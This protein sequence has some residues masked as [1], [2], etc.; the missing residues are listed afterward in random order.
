MK[1]KTLRFW[2]FKFRLTPTRYVLFALVLGMIGAA[3]V[4]FVFG[5]GAVTNLNDKWPWGLW[6]GFDLLCGIALAGGGFSTALIVHILHK[7]K[8]HSIARGAMLTSLLGYIVALISLLIDIGRWHN[9][10]RP[11]F[12]WGYHSILFEVYWCISMYTLVQILEFADIALE[13]FRFPKLKKILGYAMTPLLILGVVLPTLHQSSLGAL[14]TVMV[15]KLDPL[16]WSMLLP[17]FFV[18]SAFMLGPAMV[19]V[20]GTLWANSYCKQSEVP[21]FR[22][23]TKVTAWMLLF[24]LI[25]KV[26]DLLYRGVFGRL[27][28][29]S[30]TSWMFLAE[31]LIGVII[32]LII[33]A[34]PSLRRNP[35]GILTA[36]ALVVA[37][38]IFNRLN[39][40]F[41]GMV[42]YIGV[43]YIPSVWELLI[44]AGLWSCLILAYCFVIENFNIAPAK[45]L[46]R[47][48]E[49]AG[50]TIKN[51]G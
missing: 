32:P 46:N 27:F 35:K 7:G 15:D 25:A 38:V 43:A 19:T 23:L 51:A 33:Y 9:F 49:P 6:I 5:L 13:R 34:M 26:A 14:Y 30:F 28:N 37:G 10:W 17:V 39:V 1:R 36:S 21:V 16:W 11:W 47:Q 44:T 22:S 31:I 12:Y 40:N 24:Y 42:Q 45:V 8:Y 2:G 18:W 41:T 29:G 48:K 50:G 3:L 4:R 20:E